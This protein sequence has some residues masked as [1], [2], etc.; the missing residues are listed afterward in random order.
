M[1][2]GVDAGQLAVNAKRTMIATFQVV[3]P[4]D[5]G[6]TFPFAPVFEHSFTVCDGDPPIAESY[7]P[8][9]TSVAFDDGS[10]N[11]AGG[12]GGS[13]SSAGGGTGSSS[14]GSSGTSN[15]SDL[16]LGQESGCDCS[17]PGHAGERFW[18]TLLLALALTR[19]VRRKA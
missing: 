17:T 9:P 19:R 2:S 11:G 12:A 4:P 15:T 10:T 6:Q 5:N 8:A 7:S 16:G 18:P 1:T 14:G 13:V 3:G